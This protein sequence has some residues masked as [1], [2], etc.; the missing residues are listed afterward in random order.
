MS[1]TDIYLC[2]NTPYGP[3]DIV[4]RTVAPCIAVAADDGSRGGYSSFI[5]PPLK[6]RRQKKQ[7]VP[8]HGFPVVL[9]DVHKSTVEVVAEANLAAFAL[10]V[11][12]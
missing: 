8:D 12:S 9:V 2:P 5:R 10:L 4:L 6:K 1:A 7:A 3:T 11:L